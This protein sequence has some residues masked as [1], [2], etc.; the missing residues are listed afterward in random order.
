[1]KRSFLEEFGLEKEVIDKI[2]EANGRDINNAKAS[3]DSEA[4]KKHISDLENDIKEKEASHKAELE[5]IIKDNAIANALIRANAKTE[6]AVKALIDTDII[7]IDKS[8]NVSGL[9][10][11][12]ERLMDSEETSYLFNNTEFI[13]S[14]IGESPKE[15]EMNFEDMNYTQMCAYLENK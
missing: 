15:P 8:G 6:K 4:L 3:S 7:K 9:E 12:L 14:Q 13:G 11:Q 10:E 5:K 1:M 2:M